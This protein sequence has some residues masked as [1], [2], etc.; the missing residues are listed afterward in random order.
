M[1]KGFT[2]YELLVCI[3]I[4]SACTVPFLT[5]Y[6]NVL[7]KYGKTEI[8]SQA[9]CEDLNISQEQLDQITYNL[10]LGVEDAVDYKEIL[11]SYGLDVDEL[12]NEQV[13]QMVEELKQ[14]YESGNTQK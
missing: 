10:G 1:K 5:L 12:T 9:V 7:D 11:K 6:N 4:I 8:D 13:K 2:L 14:S 3:A